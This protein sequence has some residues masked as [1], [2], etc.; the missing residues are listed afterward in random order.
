M[1]PL[2]IYQKFRKQSLWDEIPSE[3]ILIAVSG[4]ADSVA[5]LHLASWLSLEKKYQIIVGRV[6]HHL[7]GKAS[8]RDQK[9]VEFLTRKFGIPCIVRSVRLP[10]GLHTV[11]LEEKARKLRYQALAKIAQENGA[12]SLWTAHTANDQAETFF[13]NLI[14][15]SG[16]D[17][18]CGILP[19]RPL[20]D[21]TGDPRHDSIRLVRPLLSFERSDLLRYLRSQNLRFC[22]DRTNRLLKYR[23]NWIRHR[24]IPQI[25]NLQPRIVEKISGL[26]AILQL[27][28]K[29]RDKSLGKMKRKLIKAPS[30][31]L[32]LRRFFQYD[33]SRRFQFLHRWTPQSSYSEICR[34]HEA[35]E[36]QRSKG[37]F[38]LSFPKADSPGLTPP[39]RGT[40][41]AFFLNV[42]GT[43]DL[44]SWKM[45]LIVRF[46]KNVP[47]PWFLKRNAKN[48]VAYFD[49]DKLN[50]RSA[51]WIIRA[52][53][54]GD[55]FKPFGMDGRK[56][57]QD[58]FVDAKVPFDQRQAVPLLVAGKKIRWVIGHRTDEESKIDASTQRVAEVKMQGL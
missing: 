20:G 24:L 25:Q 14:R 46:L 51:R 13:L 53:Q 44:P 16:S 43:T 22:E 1:N 21:V 39:R 28:K 57:L 3:K 33:I 56:K 32:D 6:Q 47:S 49:R 12:K 40:Q 31:R 26:T 29:W 34:I 4:G 15:G 23:R 38:L 54:P 35:L 17:G 55:R 18:L 37:R 19:R 36:R 9:F 27:E 7:R 41:K 11:G 52:W 5:L 8:L 45:R 2:G 10:Q 42:P 50:G 48:K 58:F 30:R